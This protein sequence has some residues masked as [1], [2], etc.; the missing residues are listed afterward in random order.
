MIVETCIN[1]SIKVVKLGRK[2]RETRNN[3]EILKAQMDEAIA[4]NN[5]F[6]N[7][8]EN[9]MNISLNL[10]QR[11]I[12]ELENKIFSEIKRL[13]DENNNL[14]ERI[15][16]LSKSKSNNYLNLFDNN[17][18]RQTNRTNNNRTDI[19]LNQNNKLKNF[20]SLNSLNYIGNENDDRNYVLTKNTYLIY[21]KNTPQI[22]L[23]NVENDL[24]ACKQELI[25][26]NQ[27]C[28]KILKLDQKRLESVKSRFD[29][30]KSHMDASN[31]FDLFKPNTN[32]N[33]NSDN[34]SDIFS[35]K[36]HLDVLKKMYQDA[37][38]KLMI[39]RNALKERQLTKVK[40]T[41][42]PQPNKSISQ[43]QSSSSSTSSSPSLFNNSNT[44]NGNNRYTNNSSNN[45]NNNIRNNYQNMNRNLDEINEDE[46][47]N[48]KEQAVQ[49]LPPL[50]VKS[51]SSN[52]NS[53]RIDELVSSTPKPAR[54]TQSRLNQILT[55]EQSTEENKNLE[56]QNYDYSSDEDTL[57]DN[58]SRFADVPGE[59]DEDDDDLEEEDVDDLNE[60]IDQDQNENF[61]KENNII[62]NKIYENSNQANFYPKNNYFITEEDNEEEDDNDNENNL[63]VNDDI[64]VDEKFLINQE[65]E[66]DTVHAQNVLNNNNINNIMKNQIRQTEEKKM[67]NSNNMLPG[68]TVIQILNSNEDINQNYM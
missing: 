45:N 5:D 47:Y 3:N 23:T 13:E 9:V 41:D 40:L 28:H 22:S 67:D 10:M 65:D 56:E 43:Q 30:I 1:L 19:V 26:T 55:H 14:V 2:L 38:H 42:V 20:K 31:D 39:F 15:D 35:T 11:Q 37:T 18:N 54:S 60:D 52:E 29:E 51:S 63:N 24:T 4:I 53:N 48:Y 16:S 17:N 62:N 44:N 21:K 34:M 61:K 36:E 6:I 46:E 66:I 12:N 50:P 59:G 57:S 33:N 8:R 58:D 49:N 7:Q 32:N 68:H 25:N 27:N 64:D